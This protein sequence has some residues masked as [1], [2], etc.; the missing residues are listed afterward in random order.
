M[1]TTSAINE[2]IKF[3]RKVQ[4][5]V[6]VFEVRSQLKIVKISIVVVGI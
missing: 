1:N 5:L 6:D 4:V 2:I 3:V